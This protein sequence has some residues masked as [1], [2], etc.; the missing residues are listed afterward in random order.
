[1]S[2]TVSGEHGYNVGETVI[3]IQTPVLAWWKRFFYWLTKSPVPSSVDE[4]V[5]TEISKSTMVV[6]PMAIN[7]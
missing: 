1:M 4:F 5:I 3:R 7:E 6:K 2:L